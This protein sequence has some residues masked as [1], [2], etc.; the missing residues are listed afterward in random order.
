MVRD[1]CCAITCGKDKDTNEGRSLHYPPKDA[2][3]AD[4]YRRFLKRSNTEY[5]SWKPPKR[6]CV[7]S[8][9]FTADAF[10]NTGT[11]KKQLKSGKYPT[12]IAGNDITNHVLS[13][14]QA[15]LS[16]TSP[17]SATATGLP[18]QPSNMKMFS[19]APPPN[20]VESVINLSQ[21]PRLYRP[22]FEL[23]QENQDVE[24]LK[25]RVLELESHAKMLLEER[26]SLE[27]QSTN[28]KRI[29]ST[30]QYDFQSAIIEKIIKYSS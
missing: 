28:N 10:V 19:F 5:L 18:Y 20:G 30:S 6:L 2:F 27:I 29:S 15:V 25:R 26:N 21:E 12:L 14:T 4:I 13:A 24:T 11:D 7:C 16:P 1:S 9:H 22:A 8:D 17:A 23:R 3:V